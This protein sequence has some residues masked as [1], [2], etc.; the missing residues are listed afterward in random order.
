MTPS[1]IF[2]MISEEFIK[3]NDEKVEPRIGKINYD[4]DG[5]LSEIGLKLVLIFM[6]VLI[7]VSIGM[8]ICL[9][10]K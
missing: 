6:K 4:V 3:E 1:F 10:I 8:A 2:R 5:T 9:F 7:E